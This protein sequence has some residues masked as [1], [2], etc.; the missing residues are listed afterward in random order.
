MRFQCARKEIQFLPWAKAPREPSSNGF[1][2]SMVMGVC[3]V[4]CRKKE[5]RLE[6]T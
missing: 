1:I 6:P 2:V 3:G 5:S 4:V